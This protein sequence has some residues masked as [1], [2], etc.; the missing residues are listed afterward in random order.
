MEILNKALKPERSNVKG[1]K[2]QSGI[3]TA[4]LVGLIAVVLIFVAVGVY[5]AK[6]YK[7]WIADGI[8]AGMNA[9]INGSDIPEEEKADV[10]R[11]ISR[12]KEDYLAQE[13]SIAELGLVLEAIGTCPA[14]PIGLVVQFEQSYVVP[15]GLSAE[16]KM[17]AGL[18]LNRLARGLSDGRIDWSVSEQLLAPISDPGEDGK[19]HLRSPGLVSDH[20]ILGVLVTAKNFADEAEISEEMIE[21]DISDEFLK[22]LEG[23][24]GRS[25]A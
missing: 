3:A 8:T 7:V 2:S 17:A 9:L 5:A 12:L 1:L 25:L 11:I 6:N 16:E 22:S 23:A 10:I 13:I 4:L 14:L 21:I 24:L 18:H 15:S 19:R 20:E